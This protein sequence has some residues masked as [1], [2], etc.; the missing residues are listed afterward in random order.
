MDLMALSQRSWSE[1]DGIECKFQGADVSLSG[2]VGVV[3]RWLNRATVA[4]RI[5]GGI[6]SPYA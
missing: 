2:R 1:P 5:H 6:V 3:A 4:S